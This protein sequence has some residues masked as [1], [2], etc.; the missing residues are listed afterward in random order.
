MGVCVSAWRAAVSP[1]LMMIAVTDDCDGGDN[2]VDGGYGD[3][4]IG[5][6][7]SGQ[8]TR[9]PIFCDDGPAGGA[10]RAGVDRMGGNISV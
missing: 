10:Q 8:D 9:R 1:R 6:T 5:R 2:V 3:A 7:R 4:R